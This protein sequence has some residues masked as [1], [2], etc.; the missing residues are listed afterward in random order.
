LFSFENKHSRSVKFSHLYFSNNHSETSAHIIRCL[1][2][3]K[4]NINPVKWVYLLNHYMNQRE[5][6]HVC[7]IRLIFLWIGPSFLVRQWRTTLCHLRFEIL[8]S[9]RLKTCCERNSTKF[10][11][12]PNMA[13]MFGCFFSR[14]YD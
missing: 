6:H 1:I 5:I 2:Y 12:A 11:L 10:Q 8:L 3:K 4:K 13:V 7:V 9:F 14:N